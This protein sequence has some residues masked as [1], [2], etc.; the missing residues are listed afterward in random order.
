MSSNKQAMTKNILD[1]EG[2]KAI[3]NLV[4][5][6]IYMFTFPIST[7]FLIR[8]FDGSITSSALGAIVAVQIII[9][10][11]IYQAIESQD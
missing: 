11:F 8:Y 4:K 3:S 9:A 5:Y 6:T 7:Y 10:S 2:K 1:V